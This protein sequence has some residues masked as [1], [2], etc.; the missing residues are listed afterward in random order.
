MELSLFKKIKHKAG[1]ILE[2]QLLH[3]AS[4]LA[5]RHWEL[6]GLIEI[7]FH[8]PDVDMRNWKQIPYIK[9]RVDGFSFRD[10]SPFGWDAESAT[11]SILVDS[12]HEGPGSRWAQ[13]LAVGDT[14]FYFGPDS[15]RQAP[16]PT[17]CVVGLGDASSVGHLLAL[18]QLTVPVSRFDMAIVLDSPQTEQLRDTF[19]PVLHILPSYDEL[20]GWLLQQQYSISNTSFY[21]NGNNELVVALRKLLKKMGYNQIR[22]KG[23]W[24]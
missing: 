22:V 7:D 14:A 24:S 1:K 10:Y 18:Q 11:C 17:D 6:S 23:F 4:V 20:A 9:F 12:A 5:V 8:L 15:T 2:D 13:Q 19:S 3:A 21:I 16:H